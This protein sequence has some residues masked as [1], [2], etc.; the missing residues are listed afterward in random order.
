MDLS[1]IKT[2]GE[3]SVQLAYQRGRGRTV[4]TCVQEKK[5]NDDEIYE[6]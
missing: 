1:T 4:R 6:S 3:G 5:K 2:A